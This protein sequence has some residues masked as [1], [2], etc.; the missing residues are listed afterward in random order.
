M[1]NK[2]KLNPPVPPGPDATEVDMRQF[3]EDKREYEQQRHEEQV[4]AAE[5]SPQVK[6]AESI[7][8]N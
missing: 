4:A 6:Q 7:G 3:E 1:A 5:K 8:G 2:E